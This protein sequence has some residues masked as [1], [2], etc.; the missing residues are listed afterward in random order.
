MRG[1]TMRAVVRF[2]AGLMVAA[3]FVAVS[4]AGATADA[5]GIPSPSTGTAITAV[6]AQTC[7]AA[8]DIQ[9]NHNAAGLRYIECHR[10]S[11]SNRE[12]ST[13]LWLWDNKTDGRCASAYVVIGRWSHS[14]AW[15]ST[16]HHSPRL[17]SGW[18]RGADAKVYLS[19]T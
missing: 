12:S 10:G 18:H 11:G 13:A 15:C 7:Q 1:R 6:R 4:P 14:W 9:V 8:R 17:I 3:G 19:L 16:R 5:T 2:A